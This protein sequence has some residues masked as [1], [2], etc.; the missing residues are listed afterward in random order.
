MPH[1]CLYPSQA[2]PNLFE[3]RDNGSKN[4]VRHHLNVSNHSPKH[5]FMITAILFSPTAPSHATDKKFCPPLAPPRSH[6]SSPAITW[7]LPSL[8][9][10]SG[11]SY[12][13]IHHRI[14]DQPHAPGV[15]P[16]GHTQAR[17][18]FSSTYFTYGEE[19]RQQLV[20]QRRGGQPLDELAAGHYK[21]ATGGR[22]G[23]SSTLVRK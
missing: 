23:L 2:P 13:H 12:S 6:S 9:Q 15:R 11:C 21:P 17:G 5:N 7:K 8:S 4:L 10:G 22:V 1:R 20:H 19:R 18:A 16:Q 3:S 14:L